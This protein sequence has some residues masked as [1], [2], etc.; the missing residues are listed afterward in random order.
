LKRDAANVRISEAQFD[1]IPKTADVFRRDGHGERDRQS[2]L[3][4]AFNRFEA[5]D[6]QIRSAKKFLAFDLRSIELEIKL[7]VPARGV[8]GK[9][10][11]KGRIVGDANAVRVDQ[12]VINIRMGLHPIEQFEK[13]RMQRRFAAGELENFDGTFARN[14]A[15]DAR[16]EFVERNGI[17]VAER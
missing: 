1:R 9:M 14:D 6:A 17:N 16:F 8:G 5:S 11:R 2:D 15:V 3:A 12:D 4:T 10:L 13:L 7:N